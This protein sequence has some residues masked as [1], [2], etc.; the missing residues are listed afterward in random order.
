MLVVLFLVHGPQKIL[1][2]VIG[3]GAQ[4]QNGY[5][6]LFE[7]HWVALHS[8]ALLLGSALSYHRLLPFPHSCSTLCLPPPVWETVLL[9]NPLF[10]AVPSFCPGKRCHFLI[11]PANFGTPAFHIRILIHC[12]PSPLKFFFLTTVMLA[13]S[14]LLRAPF[15]QFVTLQRPYPS[16][17]PPTQR[18]NR[19]YIPFFL[20]SLQPLLQQDCHS[21]SPSGSNTTTCG[22]PF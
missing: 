8:W 17:S 9:I 14:L 19:F 22:W 5:I 6:P 2:V 20:L 13:I 3:A 1:A 18:A 11:L 10:L 21:L 4:R 15:F 7:S 16:Y 12:F